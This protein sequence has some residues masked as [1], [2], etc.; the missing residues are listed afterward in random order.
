[1][2]ICGCV[3]K[4]RA[5]EDA[6]LPRVGSFL[7]LS[8]FFSF[9][10]F[11]KF[12]FPFLPS[13]R[14]CL[15]VQHWGTHDSLQASPLLESSKGSSISTIADAEEREE[16]EKNKKEV[17]VSRERERERERESERERERVRERVRVREWERER[18]KRN[19]Q[20]PGA[21]VNLMWRFLFFSH[22]STSRNPRSRM[23]NKTETPL[24][25]FR[26]D[27]PRRA[28]IPC[29]LTRHDHCVHD[30]LPRRERQLVNSISD[31]ETGLE[32]FQSESTMDLPRTGKIRWQ[33]VCS[34]NCSFALKEKSDGDDMIR[35][36]SSKLMKHNEKS[37]N[38]WS[39][40]SS[41]STDCRAIASRVD[42]RYSMVT[43]RE[44]KELNPLYEA[45]KKVSFDRRRPSLFWKKIPP[46]TSDGFE[47]WQEYFWNID[48]SFKRKKEDWKA[49][50][51]NSLC[52]NFCYFLPQ[53]LT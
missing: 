10:F 40:D 25:P 35:Q 34:N 44:I 30:C 38:C 19:K 14:F 11:K 9:F 41:R 8:F 33:N 5:R 22:Q 16:K 29:E 3:F 28:I 23:K 24:P 15:Y 52:K 51:K 2:E 43:T 50:I 21:L 18:E 1:M 46:E 39:N 47:T 26:L 7:F 17:H 53:F 32:L 42:L 4:E 6:R 45:R 12:Q 49:Q 31:V 48:A 36:K 13:L 37:R 20:N 27:Q